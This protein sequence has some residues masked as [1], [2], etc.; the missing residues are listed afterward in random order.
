MQWGRARQV[1]VEVK[2]KFQAPEPETKMAGPSW[3]QFTGNY[4]DVYLGMNS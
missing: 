2:D 4:I 3:F 1:S